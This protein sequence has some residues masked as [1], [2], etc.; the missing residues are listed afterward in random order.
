[1][2][3]VTTST[4]PADVAAAIRATKAELRQRV[5]DVGR[6]L[7]EVAEMV[8]DRVSDVVRRRD[9]GDS[10]WPEVAFADIAAGTVPDATRAAIRERGCAVVRGTFPREVAEGWDRALTDY[11]DANDFDTVYK[12]VDD[13]IFAGM[14]MARPSIFPIYWSQ[15]QVQARQHPNMAKVQSFLNRFWRF[16]SEGRTWFDPD[17][18]SAYPDRVRRRPP[19]AAARGLSPHVDSGKVERWLLPAYQRV[20]RHAFEG[21]WRA[22][23]PW[24][25]AFRTE[26][27]EY[28]APVMCS[29]FRTFQGWTALNDMEP[30]DG[31]LHVVPFPEAMLHLLLRPLAADVADDDLCG[32]T[33]TR[34]IRAVPEFHDLLLPALTPIPAVAPGDTVWWHGD[35]IHSVEAAANVERWNNVM[36]IPAAPWCDKNAAYAQSCFERFTVG[37]SPFDFPPEHYEASWTNRATVADLNEIGMAQFGLG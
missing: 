13:E 31:V 24:D 12:R 8:Q 25:G 28:E 32:A 4:P 22:Y 26:V 18:D 7:A 19:D 9:A 23:D 6:V 21:N 35:V 15:P 10:V 11:V 5:G 36:Y 37:E 16:E 20:Y 30:T 2:V 34:S 17:R 14:A 27:H 3:T 29:A 1:M 33:M